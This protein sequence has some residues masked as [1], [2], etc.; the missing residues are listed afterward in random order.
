MARFF[1]A[2]ESGRDIGSRYGAYAAVGTIVLGGVLILVSAEGL[3]NA[4]DRGHFRS[5]LGITLGVGAIFLAPNLIHAGG[6]IGAASAG[7]LE[8]VKSIGQDRADNLRLL[9]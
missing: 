3:G 8:G 5:M 4:S 1:K 6:I 9:R 2:M 7:F